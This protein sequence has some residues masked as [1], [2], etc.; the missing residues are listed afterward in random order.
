MT[1]VLKCIIFIRVLSLVFKTIENNKIKTAL[2]G[3]N[4]NMT[5]KTLLAGTT[6]VVLAANHIGT[7]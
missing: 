1:I 3:Y 7:F 4:V 6:A 2:S 5:Y